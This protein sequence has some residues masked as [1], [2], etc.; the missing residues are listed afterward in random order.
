M[1]H[2][3]RHHYRRHSVPSSETWKPYKYQSGAGE[4]AGA[5]FAQAAAD[6]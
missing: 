4:V 3:R 5:E 2:H 1:E 6:L